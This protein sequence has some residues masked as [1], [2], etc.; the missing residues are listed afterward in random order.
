MYA[1]RL[2]LRHASSHSIHVGERRSPAVRNSRPGVSILGPNLFRYR[3]LLAWRVDTQRS[4]APKP[5]G[6]LDVRYNVSA[7]WV[8]SGVRSENGVF[9]GR[10]AFSGGDQGWF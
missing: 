1:N 4:L 6:R 5:P 2:T 3:L 7:S 9:I 10:P 8:S